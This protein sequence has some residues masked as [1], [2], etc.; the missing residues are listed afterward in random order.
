MARIHRRSFIKTTLAAAATVTIGGTKSSGRVI[1]A[2]DTIR[3]GVAGLNGR[4]GSHVDAF[5]GMKNVQVTHLI[6]PDT[7]TYQKRLDQIAKKNQ[8]A[9]AC[10]AD[11]RTALDDKNLDAVSVATPNH[12]HSLITI[13]GCQAGKDVYVEKPCS[14][15]IH[16]GRIAVETT[17]KYKR[18]VQHGT[19][20]RSSQGWANLA[21]LAKSGKLGKLLV[22][23][24]LCY[25]SGGG[26]STRGDIGHAKPEAP[27][28]G[29]DFDLWLGPAKEQPYNANYVPYRWHWFWAFGSGDLGN[30]G[31]HQM[32]VARWLIPGARWPKSVISFGG[33]YA[34][35]DQGETPNA[36]VTC[37]D[38]GDTQLIFEVRGHKSPPFRGQSIGNVLHFEEGVVA[39]G[40]FYPKGQ[41]DGQPV[42]KVEGE[43][44]AGGSI[45]ANFIDTMRSRNVETQQADIAV[46]HVSSGLCHL[47]NISYRLGTEED[48][49]PRTGRVAG[50]DFATEALGRMAEHLKDDGIKF[51]DKGLRVGARLDFD[52]EAERFPKSDAANALLTRA[53]R[54]P[55]VVPEKVV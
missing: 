19:Q 36:L 6:D 2:N 40:K 10:L 30:Q 53:Y 27:P 44:V 35:G 21:A 48:H 16:E 25:K 24:G 28:D 32:D 15:N 41:G 17:R 20:N 5:C 55:F 34:N 13:W 7:R 31:V 47:G 42:P 33:R 50:N 4:G 23:R 26:W 8:P 12:W 9:P 29:L 46:G 1:G 22:S 11:I 49:D 37:M 52:G 38:Y 3:L 14:H 51:A 43:K 45:F 54:A 18:V 39:G